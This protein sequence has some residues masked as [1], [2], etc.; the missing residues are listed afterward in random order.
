MTHSTKFSSSENE[1]IRLAMMLQ[2]SEWCTEGVDLLANQQLEQYNSQEGAQCAMDEIDGF[3]SSSSKLTLSDPSE[4]YNK[5]TSIITAETKVHNTCCSSQRYNYTFVIISNHLIYICKISRFCR[6]Y[7]LV[8]AHT[9][10]PCEDIYVNYV[11]NCIF[12]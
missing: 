12:C 9:I 3:M 2:A 8:K 1:F 7:I 6:I 10:K 4:F 11:N 5:F